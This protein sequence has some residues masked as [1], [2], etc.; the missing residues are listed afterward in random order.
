MSAM[1]DQQFSQATADKANLSHAR[2][3]ML[4]PI[5]FVMYTISF[6]DRTNFG[7]AMPYIIQ[8][9]GITKAQAGFAAGVFV[10]G[11][12]VTQLLAGVF[13]MR[14]GSRNVVGASLILWGITAV[15]TAF[16][17]SFSQLI[18]YRIL[19]G[20]FEGPVFAATSGLLAQWFMKRERGRAFGIWN[21][22]SPVGAFLAGPISGFILAHYDWRLMMIVEGLPALIWAAL[23]CWRVPASMK[24]ASWLPA[25]EREYIQKNLDEEQEVLHHNGTAKVSNWAVLKEPAVWLTFFGDAFVNLLISGYTTW[26]PSALKAMPGMSIQAVG[27]LTGLPFILA[28]F[29]MFVIT[30]HSDKHGQERRWHSAIPCMITGVLLVI[31]GMIPEPM[32]AIQIIVL[33]LLGFTMKMFLPLIFTRLTELLPA[34]NAVTAVALVNGLANLFGGFCGPVMIGYLASTGN[35]FDSSFIALGI[36]SVVGGLLFACI[37]TR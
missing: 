19:L 2:W 36:G 17:Q 25:K 10:W 18:M 3:V 9:L 13:V 21:L 4:L 1:T 26:L 34:E 24:K 16:T 12:I 23:W 22:S 15:A 14:F 7:I 6:F 8:E 27:W 32:Y 11:Y 31:A 20:L 5:V 35:G 28:M 37:R 30:R 29:G 33:V